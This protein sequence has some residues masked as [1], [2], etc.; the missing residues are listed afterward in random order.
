MRR[1]C[2]KSL[3]K[4]QGKLPKIYDIWVRIWGMLYTDP[5]WQ[6][7]TKQE[8]TT[9]VRAATRKEMTWY[10][11]GIISSLV[12]PEQQ[13]WSQGIGKNLERPKSCLE[14]CDFILQVQGDHWSVRKQW[15]DTVGIAP[16]TAHSG[17]TQRSSWGSFLVKGSCYRFPD[18]KWYEPKWVVIHMERRGGIPEIFRR[19]KS[20]QLGDEL[21]MG[22]EQREE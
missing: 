3:V 15:G 18:K 5:R 17:D 14:D 8:V 2:H 11:W 7:Y 21:D 4:D 19:Q 6:K 9:W 22:V 13:I 1:Y 16:S 12:T 20:K 10:M